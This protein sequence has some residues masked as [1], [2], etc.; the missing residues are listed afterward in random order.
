MYS[1]GLAGRTTLPGMSSGS[2]GISSLQQ[3]AACVGLGGVAAGPFVGL[4][5]GNPELLLVRDLSG[6]AALRL[7]LALLF[8]PGLLV[9]AIGELGSRAWPPRR[10]CPR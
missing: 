8:A 9:F 5:G 1:P 6:A 2:S 7:G 3:L 4:L 10:S